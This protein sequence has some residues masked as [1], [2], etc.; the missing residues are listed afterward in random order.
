MCW[1]GLFISPSEQSCL[2]I[3]RAGMTASSLFQVQ[4][5][6]KNTANLEIGWNEHPRIRD[7]LA[8]I[9]AALHQHYRWHWHR[10]RPARS[11]SATSC[12]NL[13]Q[14]SRCP[15]EQLSQPQGGPLSAVDQ[16]LSLPGMWTFAL[17]PISCA[18]IHCGSTC[19][20]RLETVDLDSTSLWWSCSHLDS[21]HIN[22]LFFHGWGWRSWTLWV[23]ISLCC[24]WNLGMP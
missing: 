22:D 11:C 3:Q 14:W 16:L 20:S 1:C 10:G 17:W 18:C 4:H 21:C 2:V 23:Y 5:A 15:D 6:C 24:W 13:S 9:P 7:N 8:G 19:L 12:S